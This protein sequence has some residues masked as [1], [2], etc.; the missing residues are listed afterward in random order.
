MPTPGRAQDAAA[1][2]QITPGRYARRA[3]SVRFF[4][5]LYPYDRSARPGRYFLRQVHAPRW[6]VPS[7]A[8]TLDAETPSPEPGD[9][10]QQ[11]RPT[12]GWTPQTAS[13]DH[14][15][16]AT[17]DFSQ[18]RWDPPHRLACRRAEKNSHQPAEASLPPQNSASSPVVARPQVPTWMTIG[19]LPVRTDAVIQ[20]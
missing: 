10:D 20:T 16:T 1:H 5:A 9:A 17:T 14:D 3:P 7:G 6:P 15:I 13:A 19:T 4:Q 8:A 2:H 11:P 12:S 18:R